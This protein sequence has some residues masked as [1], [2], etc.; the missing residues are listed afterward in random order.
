[1]ATTQE[2]YVSDYWGQVRGLVRQGHIQTVEL[3]TSAGDRVTDCLVGGEPMTAFDML[4]DA[5]RVMAECG[6]APHALIRAGTTALIAVANEKGGNGRDIASVIG[7]RP[8]GIERIGTLFAA[9]APYLIGEVSL[10][11]ATILRLYAGG[12]MVQAPNIRRGI[13]V[14]AA[15]DSILVPH[16][17]FSRQDE[18][19]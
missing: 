8:E 12:V 5:D 11:T 10:S 18:A 17:N 14:A 9:D 4:P 19:Y 15:P 3:P 2:A 6:V 7:L 1:M 13:W 16:A